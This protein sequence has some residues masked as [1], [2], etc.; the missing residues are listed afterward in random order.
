MKRYPVGVMAYENH[1]EHTWFNK[2]AARSNKLTT[3]VAVGHSIVDL[4]W[5]IHHRVH[6]NP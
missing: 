1:Q 6:A 5:I 3:R 2:K 4:A